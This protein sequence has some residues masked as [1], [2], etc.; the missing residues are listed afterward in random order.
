MELRRGSLFA[1]LLTIGNGVCGFAAL[2]KLSQLQLA[3]DNSLVNP[4]NLVFSGYLILLGMLFD[5]FDGKVA[6]MVKGSTE[7]GAQLDSLCDLITF[8]LVPAFMI[9]QMQLGTS[10]RWMNVVWFFSLAYFLGALLRLARFNVENSPEEEA[11]LCFKGLPSPAAAGCVASL[12]IFQNY[13]LKAEQAEI[14]WVS[15][16][17]FSIE[18]MKTFVTAISY[19]L[20]F[21]GVFLGFTMVSSRLKFEHVGSRIF[22]K[23]HSWEFFV[24]LIFAALLLAIVPEVFLPLAFIGYLVWT[25]VMFLFRLV[26][27]GRRK[28]QAD[29]EEPQVLQRS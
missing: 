27:F 6:R 4:E 11:H 17:L 20:P 5:A 8:G 12:V 21:L 29:E 13:V 7:L 18:S 15:E 10:P 14:K 24:S 19:A 2:I 26:F 16:N 23:S 25:P 3:E 22:G 1:N 28:S 9:F